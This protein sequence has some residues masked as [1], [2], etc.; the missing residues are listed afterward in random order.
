MKRLGMAMVALVLAPAL[1]S[2]LIAAPA[3]ATEAK[4]PPA[5]RQNNTLSDMI[6]L[7]IPGGRV[8]FT[9]DGDEVI[10]QD[11]R[12]DGYGVR[13]RVKDVTHDPDTTVYTLTNSQ[14]VDT[15]V[16]A[17]AK[18]GGR[19]DLAEKHCFR[20]TIWLVNNGK[21]VSPKD[22]RQWRNY[23]NDEDR[24]CPGVH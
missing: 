20:F 8:Y 1:P 12:K 5:Q 9:A 10:A 6:W 16:W 23:N 22:Y 24:Y 17:Y 15:S 3:Q 4:T 13:V 2:M 7:E 18:L 19:Y 14:G 11:T 21:R